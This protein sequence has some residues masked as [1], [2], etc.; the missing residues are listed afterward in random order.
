M[1]SNYVPFRSNRARR[2]G[3]TFMEM[4]LA[5]M[6]TVFVGGAIASMMFAVSHATAASNDSRGLV[7]QQKLIEVRLDTAIRGSTKVL[8]KGTNYIVLW[9]SDSR[10]NSAPD[11][12]EIRRIE[13]SSTA[14]TVTSYRMPSS[15][16][17]AT[18]DSNEVNYT[19]AT[20]FDSVTTALKG[21]TKF[22]AEVWS[23]AAYGWTVTLDN[24][25][26]QSARLVSYQ[27]TTQSG[28]NQST[29]A[30]ASALRN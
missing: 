30:G 26:A 16:S 4:I 3:F 18:I 25:T 21:N 12:S 22:P 15:W 1:I 23:N 7:L 11:L 14:H 20:D 17:Q 24:A 2:A 19:L 8:A 13:Y 5:L 10:S 6:V 29:V 9:M 27:V 28:S